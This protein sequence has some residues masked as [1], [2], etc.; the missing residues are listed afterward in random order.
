MNKL[1]LDKKFFK[2]MDPSQASA[3]AKS[4]AKVT[5]ERIPMFWDKELTRA[6][7]INVNE[8]DIIMA[9]D[10]LKELGVPRRVVVKFLIQE[11]RD[12]FG[13]KT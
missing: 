1:K 5:L 11:I 8:Q 6:D 3:F 7:K 9:L 10:N 4:D 2:N 12:I 13:D